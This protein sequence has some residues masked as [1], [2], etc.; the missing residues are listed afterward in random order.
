MRGKAG[1]EGDQKTRRGLDGMKSHEPL[2]SSG[3]HSEWY[4][5]TVHEV[6]AQSWKYI[7][8]SH[9]PSPPIVSDVCQKMKFLQHP[10]SIHKYILNIVH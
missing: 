2:T 8:P 10:N 6:S 1:Q 3:F 7:A 9:T 5:K 4:A